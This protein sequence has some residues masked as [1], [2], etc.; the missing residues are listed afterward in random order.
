MALFRDDITGEVYR[1]TLN[2]SGVCIVPSEV[3]VCEASKRNYFVVSVYG[4]SDDVPRVTTN[5]L[6]VDLKPSGF[7][8]AADPGAPTQTEYEQILARYGEALAACAD[9]VRD[10]EVMN[11][12]KQQRY[13]HFESV[14]LTVVQDA[15]YN[16]TGQE[17]QTQSGGRYAEY[18]ISGEDMLLVSGFTW[19]S[20]NTFPLGAFYSASGE[21]IE[22]IGNTVSEGH[23]KELHYVPAGAAKL[24]INGN[25]WNEPALEKFVPGDLE[26]VLAELQAQLG[27][28][29]N[30]WRGKKVVWLGTSVPFGQYAEKSYPDEAAKRLG[31]ELVNCS[32]PGLAA[33][34][35]A[36]GAPLTHGSVVLTKAEYTAAGWS[37]PDAPVDYVP[38]GS[39][40]DY[41]RTHENIF[42]AANA[43]AELYVFDLVPNNTNFDT[44]DWDAFDFKNWAYADG[45]PFSA[46]RTTFL[47]AMLFL[48]D[49]LYTLNESARMVFILGSG[50]AY[51]EGK[52]ALQKLKDQW[53]VAII[54]LWG[55]MNTSPK[56]LQK[57]FAEDGTNPHPSTFAHEVMGRML[58]SRLPGVG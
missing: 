11:R 8:D 44:T 24:V 36:D 58:S 1:S 25:T 21:L 46:H 16:T 47:G 29:D 4:V 30:A 10:T 14:E 3:L 42:C 40:N 35:A 5:E 55:D 26:A 19:S 2:S 56:S 37:I 53:N 22:K 33:H 38:G 6:R 52:T 18:D 20:Y 7:G 48:M 17:A 41:Y 13:G 43:D 31:F 51:W 45:S 28:A 39:Y 12:V 9:A 23:T 34:T 15:V 50:F 57:L 32:V 54:D 27:A 49:R